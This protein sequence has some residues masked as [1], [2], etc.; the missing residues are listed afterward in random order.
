MKGRWRVLPRDVEVFGT[1]W[2][3]LRG[4]EHVAVMSGGS[5]LEL[6]R[7]IARRVGPD[8]LARPPDFDA[9]L[10]N[11]RAIEQSRAVGDAVLDQRLVSGIGNMWKADASGLRRSRR[12]V[13]SRMCPTRS[14]DGCSRRRSSG[15]RGD[16]TA[17]G[18]GGGPI[19]GSGCRARAVGRRSA[20]GP[21]ATARAWPIGARSVS[22]VRFGL[23]SSR[24]TLWMTRHTF[25]T[26]RGTVPAFWGRH[27]FG[28]EE[29][30]G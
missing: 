4:D 30:G 25:S 20:R 19:G 21:R 12:G 6:D 24:C 11:L 8:I 5:V 10:R 23:R 18:A 9:M 16:S 14:C 3:V 15:C 29:E 22:R 27:T 7:G 1:P 13:R 26:K 2:L 28:T 17:C